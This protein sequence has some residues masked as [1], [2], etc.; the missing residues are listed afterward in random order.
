MMMHAGKDPLLN[1][2]DLMMAAIVAEE[3]AKKKGNNSKKFCAIM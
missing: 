2:A 1:S 3:M